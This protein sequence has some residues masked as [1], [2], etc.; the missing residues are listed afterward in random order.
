MFNLQTVSPWSSIKI[1]AAT[2]LAAS[3]IC[4]T[5]CGN[6]VTTAPT[7]A[8]LNQPGTLSGTLYGGQQAI[9]GSTVSLYAVGTG[10]YGSAGTLLA[11]TK[12]LTTTGI[13]SFVQDPTH[14]NT[15]TITATYSCP[16]STTLIYII[17]SGGD[18]IGT[19]VNNNTAIG[20]LAALGQCGSLPA[21]T[22]INEAT[23]ITSIFALAQYIN[24]GTTAGTMTI[25]SPNTTQ[26]LLGI[27][28]AF[29]TASNLT[30][31]A[32]GAVNTTFTPASNVTGV[33]M[34]ATPEAAKV[35]LMANIL[36]SCINN[37]AASASNCTALFTNAVPPS[38]AV[39]SQPGATF[40]TAVDT[41]QATYYMATNP[42]DGSTAALTNLYNLSTAEPIFMPAQATQPSDWTVGITYTPSGTCT[43][44][45]AVTFFSTP[46]ASAVDAGGN[47]WV[48]SNVATGALVELS[49]GGAALNCYGSIDLGKNVTVDTKGN[50]WASGNNTSVYEV[51]AGGTSTLTWTAPTGGGAV[52]A[53]G[54]GNVFLVPYTGGT[55]SAGVQEY[56]GAA[57]ATTT[58][59]A[60]Q[61][62]VIADTVTSTSLAVAAD[63]TGRLF[64]QPLAP[65]AAEGTPYDLY[66]SS[67]TGSVNGYNAALLSIGSDL[68]QGSG[69]TVDNSGN[70]VIVNNCCTTTN[71]AANAFLKVTPGASGAVSNPTLS[72]KYAGGLNTARSVS[73]DGAGNYWASM[74]SAVVAATTT[75]VAAA[76]YGVAE[77]DKNFNSLSPAGTTP[78]SCASG[79][80]YT[81]GAFQDGD[82]GTNVHAA[83]IDPSG[84]VW[85]PS[86]STANLIVELVGVAVPVVTPTSV[87]LSTGA[88]GSKP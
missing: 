8:G 87:A 78:S 4:M 57:S 80:C 53:D 1:M 18:P 41:L 44:A 61:V 74:G 23:T 88:Q 67:S 45:S 54:S 65:S 6:M 12:T 40:S 70:V 50:V 59:S 46:Y 34:T 51:L 31:W 69:L 13:F 21:F 79:A 77:V 82:I 63:A 15:S 84:N 25:G 76:I 27:T 32:Q 16:S 24:P 26:A 73:V 62:G 58:S 14:I 3:A 75:P 2:L 49:P 71:P 64:V 36:T 35:N 85:L 48:V 66:P 72:A 55:G 22:D 10:G 20:L 7:S 30:N 68:F 28:N 83:S 39:T 60:T 37:T 86:G 17:A 5:G 47:V 52:A 42:S 9:S 29:T 43:N 19:G 81:N 33:T 11:Q 56:V 38:A